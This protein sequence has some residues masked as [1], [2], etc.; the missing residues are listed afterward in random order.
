[1]SGETMTDDSLA[2][3]RRYRPGRW[4]HLENAVMSLLTRVG[5]M[6]HSYLLL[7]RGRRTGKLRRT[8]VVLVE[9]H[10]RR[11]LVAPY[12]VVGWVHNARAAGEVTL[13]RRAERRTYTIREVPAEE[14]GPVLQRYLD[15]APAPRKYFRARRGEPV[16]RFVAEAHLHPV[17]EL[18]PTAVPG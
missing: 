8:P 7:T 11:W 18:T 1:M 10:G 14:A 17:F 5:L 4:R 16:E 15:L 2:P 6:P 13:V 3:V 12:G 9:L